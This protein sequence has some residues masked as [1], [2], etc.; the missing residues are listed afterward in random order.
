LPAAPP[1]DPAPPRRLLLTPRLDGMDGHST[2]SRLIAGALAAEAGAE[3][4][5][6]LTL[7][8][9]AGVR[10]LGPRGTV[11]GAGRNRLRY[12]AHAARTA[13]GAAR[14]THVVCAQLHLLPAALPLLVRGARLTAVL[15]GI[16]AW[17]HVRARERALLRRAGVLAISAHTAA[18]FRSANPELAEQEIRVCH[19]GAPPLG[20]A[21]APAEMGGGPFALIVGRMAAVERY[22]GHDTLLE[23]W[24]RV[25]AAAPGARLVVAGEGDDRTRLQEKARALGLDP[26]VHFLGEVAPARLLALYAAC[27]FFV[28]PSRDEG[29]GLVFLEAMRAG[30]ACLAA[31]GAAEEIVR[32]EETGLLVPHDD[33]EA[34]GAAV[35]RLFREPETRARMGRAG[36]ARFQQHFTEEHFRERFFE[37]LPG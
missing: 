9:P 36:E 16:E 24:P 2:A 35:V 26:L 31:R 12:L 30:R 34:L 1:S 7:L 19:L 3:P 15:C 28:M 37:A 13:L 20:A 21:A 18:R 27:A 6:V 11:R 10:A 32:H 8:E 33:A 23:L 29:F 22:K 17:T 25:A 5:R 14:P 4:A